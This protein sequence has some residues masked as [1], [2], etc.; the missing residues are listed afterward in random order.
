MTKSE[1]NMTTV[2]VFAMGVADALYAAS[3][4]KC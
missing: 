1:E 3:Y 4:H 2:E